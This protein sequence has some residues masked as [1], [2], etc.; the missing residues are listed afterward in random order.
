MDGRIPGMEA[1]VTPEPDHLQELIIQPA[2]CTIYEDAAAGAAA[3][4][5]GDLE[6]RAGRAGQARALCAHAADAD[7]SDLAE[8]LAAT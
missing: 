8:L 7:V 4:R 5:L 1:F 6:P 3:R 2:E